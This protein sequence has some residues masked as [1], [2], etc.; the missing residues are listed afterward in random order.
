MLAPVALVIFAI[1]LL[2]VVT[3]AGGGTQSKNQSAATKQEQRDLELKRARARRAA[4]GNKRTNRLP[5]T[6]YIV[7]TGDT[8]GS[9]AQK[10][11][12]PV[13]RLQNLNPSLD[14]Q[15]LVS[16]QRIRLR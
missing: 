15:A 14:P 13:A 9:I 2:V 4:A 8:L 3:S 12:V 16:G 5:Q 10:T 6:V 7:K 1:A 11:G